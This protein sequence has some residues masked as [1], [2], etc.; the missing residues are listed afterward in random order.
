MRK[1]SIWEKPA[2]G[3]KVTVTAG[4]Y[5]GRRGRK[6]AVSRTAEYR[7]YAL[8]RFGPLARFGIGPARAVLHSAYR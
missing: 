2:F 5:R 7:H 1:Q 3:G 8:I 6:A 4:R